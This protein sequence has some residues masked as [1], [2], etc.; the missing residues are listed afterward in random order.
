MAIAMM[1]AV[2]NNSGR[3]FFSAHPLYDIPSDQNSFA[4][5]SVRFFPLITNQSH[6]PLYD[7]ITADQKSIAC[8]PGP[9]TR[10]WRLEQDRLRR[11]RDTVRDG[12]RRGREEAREW[13]LVPVCGG[14][15]LTR[16][17]ST[18]DHYTR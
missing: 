8:M 11:E 5:S 12:E 9:E 3:H 7:F 6:D 4:S 18:V 10:R 17:F 1:K 16:S 14:T 15:N 2:R 13:N